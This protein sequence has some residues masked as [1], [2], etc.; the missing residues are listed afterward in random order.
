[1]PSMLSRFYFLCLPLK[2]LPRKREPG[3]LGME[4]YFQQNQFGVELVHMFYIWPGLLPPSTIFL[5]KKWAPLFFFDMEEMER[6]LRSP[7]QDIATHLCH[8]RSL[9]LFARPNNGRGIR[10][11][12]RLWIG[13]DDLVFLL[14]FEI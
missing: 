7:L 5:R 2:V 12:P 8:M 3:Q 1:M 14:Q 9:P 6:W 11:E 4:Q 10:Q 13:I